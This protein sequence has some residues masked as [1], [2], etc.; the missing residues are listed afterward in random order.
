MWCDE[1]P[2]TI[3]AMSITGL[4]TMGSTSAK[5]EY[6][7]GT[8]YSL[9]DDVSWV[10]GAHQLTFGGGYLQGRLAEFTHFASTGQTNFNGAKLQ[11]SGGL[12]AAD[13]FLGKINTFFQGLPNTNYS[14]QNMVNL[15][16]TD[17]WKINPHLTVNFGVR[18]VPF[19]PLQVAS[20]SAFDMNRFLSGTRSTEIGRA[21]V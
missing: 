17:I 3:G 1:N 8:S 6:W 16:V 20:I 5:G 12:G 18:W 10:K 2:Q 4:F 7:T 19:L 9:N 13:F 21:H 11:T 14:R 15:Y